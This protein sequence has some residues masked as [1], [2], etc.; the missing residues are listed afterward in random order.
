VFAKQ[1]THLGEIPAAQ[2]VLVDPD[3]EPTRKEWLEHLK[4][5]VA[6]Y[7]IPREF[8]V[9]DALET[10]ATGKVRRFRPGD[11]PESDNER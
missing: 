10:T 9:V 8:T 1:H 7:K 2:I 11:P 4:E 6:R 3:R 5:R